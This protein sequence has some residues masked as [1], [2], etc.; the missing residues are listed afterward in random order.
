M[1]ED[2]QW[3]QGSSTVVVCKLSYLGEGRSYFVFSAN[4]CFE[5]LAEYY[6]NTSCMYGV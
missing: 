3:D 5:G 4:E 6:V 2:R 1:A